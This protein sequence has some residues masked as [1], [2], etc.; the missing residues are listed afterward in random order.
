MG[1]GFFIKLIGTRRKHVNHQFEKCFP[2]NLS[3]IC[4]TQGDIKN[5]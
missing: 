1:Y 2:K 5:V 3:R 4:H